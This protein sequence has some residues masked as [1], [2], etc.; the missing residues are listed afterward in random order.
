MG[1]P[2]ICIEDHLIKTRAEG[3]RSPYLIA[4]TGQCVV[5]TMF[6]QTWQ[7]HGF[8]GPTLRVATS[9]ALSQQLPDSSRL[10]FEPHFRKQ[11]FLAKSRCRQVPRGARNIV[12]RVLDLEGKLL[13]YL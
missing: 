10:H 3:D 2:F 6:P 4:P 13:K 11:I 12:L 7:P 9:V 5:R 8:G 1:N